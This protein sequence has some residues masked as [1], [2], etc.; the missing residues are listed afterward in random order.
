MAPY[1][2]DFPYAL[3]KEINKGAEGKIYEICRIS[4]KKIF[5]AKMRYNPWNLRDY[6]NKVNIYK[7]FLAEVE[8]LSHNNH[9]NVAKMIE[10]LRNSVGD[11]FIIMEYFKEGNLIDNMKDS[12]GKVRLYEE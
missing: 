8:L 1:R 11:L 10:A 7:D 2:E 5:A 12:E 9:N 4:D 6:S 3:G